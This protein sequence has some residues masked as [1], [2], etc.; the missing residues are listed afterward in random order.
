MNGLVIWKVEA[1]NAAHH[2]S[3]EN[4]AKNRLIDARL[5]GDGPV[6]VSKLFTEAAATDWLRGVLEH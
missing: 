5:R 6:W 4:D 1:A 3:D 2:C